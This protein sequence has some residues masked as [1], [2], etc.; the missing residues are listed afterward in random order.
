LVKEASSALSSLPTLTQKE[1]QGIGAALGI[2]TLIA[3]LHHAARKGQR[4]LDAEVSAMRAAEAERDAAERARATELQKT[5]RRT[6]DHLRVAM[7]RRGV[8]VMH[9]GVD[10]TSPAFISEAARHQRMSGIRSWGR[11]PDFFKST[12]TPLGVVEF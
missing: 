1:I 2:G 7:G 8:D 10:P 12:K 3:V 11:D 5:R 4:Q 9:P 6:E